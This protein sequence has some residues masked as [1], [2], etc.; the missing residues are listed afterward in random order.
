MDLAPILIVPV[1]LITFEN[2]PIFGLETLAESPTVITPP[3][4][5]DTVENNPTEFPPFTFIAVPVFV[6]ALFAYT[7]FASAP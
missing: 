1:L 7:P 4:F 2:I 6:N 3:L 5:T